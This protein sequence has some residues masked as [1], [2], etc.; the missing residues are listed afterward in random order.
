MLTTEAARTTQNAPPAPSY[1]WQWA[2]AFM[3]SPS[4]SWHDKECLGLLLPYVDTDGTITH[5]T[6]GILVE[7]V[8]RYGSAW[9]R[10]N[11]DRFEA[12]LE[13]AMARQPWVIDGRVNIPQSPVELRIAH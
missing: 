8:I 11:R 9:G 5:T 6:D 7:M 4:L 12:Y 3:A 1:P 2:D 13:H 10:K